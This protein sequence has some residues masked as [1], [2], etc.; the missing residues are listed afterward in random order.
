MEFPSSRFY[1][2]NWAYRPPLDHNLFNHF[3]VDGLYTQAH[4]HIFHKRSGNGKYVEIGGV[5]YE[6]LWPHKNRQN[7][8]KSGLFDFLKGD[9]M[10]IY[11]EHLTFLQR[12]YKI[13]DFWV[14]D[15]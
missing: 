6:V 7:C 15:F 10:W 8:N 2:D 1:G 5:Y 11:S 3:I 9:K 13:F 12:K 14:F 4:I